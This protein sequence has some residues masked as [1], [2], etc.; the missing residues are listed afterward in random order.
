MSKDEAKQEQPTAAGPSADAPA[1]AKSER[2]QAVN[3]P[4]TP[5][6]AVTQG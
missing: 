4:V 6:G 2:R 3:P 1:A 5:G